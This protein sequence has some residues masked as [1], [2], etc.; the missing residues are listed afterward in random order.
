MISGLRTLSFL[1]VALLVGC[2]TERAAE[3][4][5]PPADLDA[6]F[7]T[8]L[9]LV[10]SGQYDRAL[11][12]VSPLLLG[13]ERHPRR[14]AIL[15]VAAECR[16]HRGDFVEAEGLYRALAEK[17]PESRFARAVPARR[18]AIG[19]E[20]LER[21][22]ATLLDAIANDRRPAIDALGRAA[23][24]DPGSELADD[25]FLKLAAAHLAEGRADLAVAA[26]E[27]LIEDYPESPLAEEAW[28]RLCE[29]WRASTRGAGYDPEP[30]SETRAAAIRY[31]ERYG[32]NGR[33]AELAAA[34]LRDAT[35]EIVRHEESIAD[36]YERR[37]NSIGA[38][39]HREN[40]R[41]LRGEASLGSHSLDLLRAPRDPADVAPLPSPAK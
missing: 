5:A 8:A 35:L 20:L 24:D 28:F 36:F 40:A 27:R 38:E 16:Y 26:L 31:L 21:P 32:P 25:A 29:A 7:A 39:L 15:F 37:G 14:D 12:V 13:T 18:L 34:R 41:R 10:G 23:V 4:A 1:A 30:L 2:S 11:D 19:I 17:H 6:R 33:F 22:P 9:Q 3:H